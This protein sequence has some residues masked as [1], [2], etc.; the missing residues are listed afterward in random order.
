MMHA[1]S[2]AFHGIGEQISLYTF[3]N[4]LSERAKQQIAILI[5]FVAFTVF[6]LIARAL[7]PT[8][9]F[10]Y[11]FTLS[12]I[13]TWPGTCL[14]V[15]LV[16]LFSRGADETKRIRAMFI[17]GLFTDIVCNFAASKF[18]DGTPNAAL[19]IPLLALGNLGVLAAAIAIGLLVARGLQKPNYLIMAAIVGAVTDIF[20]VS[21]GPSKHVLDSQMF[22][23]VSYQWGVASTGGIFPCVGAGDFIFLALYFAGVRRFNLDDRKTL[24]AMCLAIAT[25]YLSLLLYPNGI[26]ALPFMATFLLLVHGRDLVAQMRELNLEPKANQGAL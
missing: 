22:P 18:P 6:A 14:G 10:T 12:F 2:G 26:P 21:A 15:L 11:D 16:Y 24:V 20:S 1:A 25:G 8:Y 23:Y 4:S 7:P 19:S 5:Y 9:D 3:M 17:G 13:T